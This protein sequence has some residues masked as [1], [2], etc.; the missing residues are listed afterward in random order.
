M[1]SF[2]IKCFKPD[3]YSGRSHLLL[4]PRKMAGLTLRIILLLLVLCLSLLLI[5][6]GSEN[7]G[8][9]SDDNVSGIE[10]NNAEDSASSDTGEEV[11]DSRAS[12]ASEDSDPSIEAAER[13]AVSYAS[14]MNEDLPELTII[15]SE[16]AG[17]WARVDLEPVDRSAERAAVLLNYKGDGWVVVGFGFV[18]P[19]DYPEAPAELFD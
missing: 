6:C 3:K 14:Q 5:G 10:E 4:A 16:M 18:V 8:K 1:L 7:S 9:A 12:P 19:E 13:K 17:R 15:N 11:D 2:L